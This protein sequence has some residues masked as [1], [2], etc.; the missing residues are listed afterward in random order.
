MGYKVLRLTEK[1][2]TFVEKIKNIMKNIQP[3]GGK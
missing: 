1:D 3:I 2:D